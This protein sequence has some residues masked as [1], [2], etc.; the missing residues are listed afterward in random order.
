MG[1]TIITLSYVWILALS[2]LVWKT[3]EP[4]PALRIWAIPVTLLIGVQIILGSL[5]SGMQAA[6]VATDWPLMNGRLLPPLILGNEARFVHFSH[7]L[8]AYT[9]VVLIAVLAVKALRTDVER[10]VKLQLG[11]G[12]SLM[13][14]LQVTLGVLVLRGTTVDGVPLDRAIVHQ[15]LGVVMLLS[16]TYTVN[17]LRSSLAVTQAPEH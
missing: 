14:L 10:S 4:Q 15:A 8:V 5:M 7:R 11:L 16:M 3:A 9:L 6:S 17:R 13:V 1:L 12:M 2:Q